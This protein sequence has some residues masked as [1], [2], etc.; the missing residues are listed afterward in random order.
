MPSS[1]L[2]PKR[3]LSDPTDGRSP[4]YS[5]IIPAYNEAARVGATVEKVLAYA[6]ATGMGCR[7]HRGE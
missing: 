7:D 1:G 3:M 4:T 5:I 2:H 6:A